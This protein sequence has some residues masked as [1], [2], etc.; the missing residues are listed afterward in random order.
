MRFKFQP[1][2]WSLLRQ[3]IS[4]A[5]IAGYA[6]ANIIGLSVILIGVLFFCD[7]QNN[8][9]DDDK[10]F[11][12]D[13]VVLSKRVSGIGFTPVY[14]SEDELNDLANQ[15]WVR[16][17]GKF[18]SSKFAVNASVNMGGR[19]MSSYMFFESVP[20]E[21][22]DVMPRDWEFSPEK[23]FIPIMLSKDYLTLY[24][25][26]FAVPQGL[27]Q[28]SE[29]LVSAI[30]IV[31]RLTG[32]SMEHEFYEASVVGFSSRL[33]TI[34]VPQ[35]FMDWANARYAPNEEQNASRLIVKVDRMASEEMMDYLAERHI[36]VAG[37]KSDNG[38]I[39]SFLGIVS[40]VVT[41][42]GILICCLA[43][44]ILILSIFLLLQ[45]SREKL[46]NLMLLGYIP[47]HIAHYYEIIVVATNL[48]VAVVA[49][50]AAFAARSLWSASLNDIGLG[51]ASPMP[52]ILVAAA[53][54]VGVTALDLYII[55]TR[56]MDIWRNA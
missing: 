5:Q 39:S 23:R 56:V 26:G 27:P 40:M 25:F 37:D 52:T 6:I 20:D 32:E 55:R 50:A 17:I 19:T 22:F 24:N 9:G 47:A 33:N 42:N 29:E 3:N 41:N 13:F 30:P 4:K 15:K 21:F 38:K 51:D 34:A 36:E 18:A 46:R 14:F 43:I 31:L 12:D 16:K 11:S 54:I 35:S 49:L 10:F 1:D 48:I 53:Y 2:V 44:F 7:S 45:K 28:V 8:S